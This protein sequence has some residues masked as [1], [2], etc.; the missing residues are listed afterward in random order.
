MRRAANC[1][2]AFVCSLSP[3]IT[4]KTSFTHIHY[5]HIHILE[6]V[7]ACEP[8]YI[9]SISSPP[10]GTNTPNETHAQKAMIKFN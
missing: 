9:R 5:A 6:I 2:H 4:K 8:H 10:T 1:N 3:I 7:C